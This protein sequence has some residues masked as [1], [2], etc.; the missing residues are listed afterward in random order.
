[1]D[2][3]KNLP[4]SE[5]DILILQKLIEDG[6]KSSAKISKEIDLGREVINYRIKR[7]V[8]ENLIVKFIPKINEKKIGYQEHII[9]IQL[10]IED[11]VSKDKF[12]QEN[13]GNK[14]LVWMLKKK[15]GWDLI[16]RIYSQNI[17]EFRLKLKEILDR[18]QNVIAK[19]YTIMS[20]DEIKQN[21]KDILSKNLFK[22]EFIKKD[23][24]KIK[25]NST[26]LQ[27]DDK[28]RKIL[29]LLECDGREHYSEIG[30]KISMS[31]DTI[32]YRIEKMKEQGIIENFSPV[33]NF[34]K[35]GFFYYAC[36]IKFDYISDKN[37]E[38]FE[39]C[40]KKNLNVVKAI[41]SFNCEEYFLNLV[42]QKEEECKIFEKEIKL[43]FENKIKIFD[44]FRVD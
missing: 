7:L 16:V 38:E 8:K 3:D 28:D 20:I 11:K 44:I 9:F 33:L 4:L 21:E 22:N 36:V 35:L 17:E 39:E 26:I 5:K 13:I 31:S 1:M 19:Y 37:K 18:F 12:I 32:K 24:R 41:K 15:D 43:E 2:K 23:F 6:R 30:K 10:N 25:D 40:L 29:N 27:L 42:F 14:Y 34:S